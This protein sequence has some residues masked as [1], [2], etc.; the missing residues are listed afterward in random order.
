MNE[1]GETCPQTRGEG[2]NEN[3]VAL[4]VK[5]MEERQKKQ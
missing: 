4:L 1:I 2:E 3:R 5:E